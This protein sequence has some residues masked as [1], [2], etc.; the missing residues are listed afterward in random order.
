MNHIEV[1]NLM[2]SIL[3][4]W[5]TFMVWMM[6]CIDFN[7]LFNNDFIAKGIKQQQQP[8]RSKTKLGMG[9]PKEEK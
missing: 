5:S 4:V 8:P 1:E 9:N 2:A 7:F 3:K 6:D